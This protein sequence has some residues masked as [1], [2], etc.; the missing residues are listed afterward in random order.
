MDLDALNRNVTRLMKF[1]ERVEKQKVV[2]DQDAPPLNDAKVHEL[3]ERVR[4]FGDRLDQSMGPI[5]EVSEMLPAMG[6]LLTWFQ[7]NRPMLEGAIAMADAFDG[8]NAPEQ[9]ADGLQEGTGAGSEAPA[10]DAPSDPQ[11]SQEAPQ[12]PAGT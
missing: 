8:P 10:P 7:Q 1:M 6:E 5:R 2:S 3:E 9:A 11:A 12:A 4:A